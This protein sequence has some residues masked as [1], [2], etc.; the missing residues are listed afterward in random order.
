MMI[1]TQHRQE[2]RSLGELFGDLSREIS[3]LVRDEVTLARVEM[4]RKATKIAKNAGILAIGGALAYAG[5][6]ALIAFV[7]LGLIELGLAAWLSALLVGV[8][9]TA[10]GAALAKKGLDAIKKIDLIP[11]QTVRTLKEDE[12]WAKS[13]I[14]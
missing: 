1:E 3:N 14:P 9:V 8:V 6:L 13:T 12:E 4:T 2:G 10:V 7:I 5:V 11:E